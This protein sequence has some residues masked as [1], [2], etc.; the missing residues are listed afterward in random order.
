MIQIVPDWRDKTPEQILEFISVI[1]ERP[2]MKWWKFDDIK[3]EYDAQTRKAFATAMQIGGQQDA[4]IQ[5]AFLA[6]SAG[7]GIQ[8]HE[9][10]KVEAIRKLAAAFQWS[11]ELLA[12]ALALGIKKASWWEHETKTPLPTLEQ[13][14]AAKNKILEDEAKAEAVEQRRRE[15]QELRNWATTLTGRALSKI[16]QHADAGSEPPTQ[17]AI[18]ALLGGE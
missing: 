2:T 7:R 9:S 15:Y 18:L 11:E 6:M 12:K 5:T 3:D 13:V 10:D 1:E 14:T 16:S 17:A 4:D 8:L